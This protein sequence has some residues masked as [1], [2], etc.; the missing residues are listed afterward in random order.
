MSEY[1]SFSSS[2]SSLGRVTRAGI[3]NAPGKIDVGPSSGSSG[4]GSVGF[5]TG[6]SRRGL[7]VLSGFS[8]FGP[9]DSVSVAC[10]GISI[11]GRGIVSGFATRGAGAGLLF[12]FFGA[13]FDRTFPRTLPVR[14][15]VGGGSGFAST[16]SLRKYEFHNKP[17]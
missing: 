8:F 7:N 15:S 3:G 5:E 13:G 10:S 6:S 17:L 14:G 11:L 16:A 9:S 4:G 2:G 1:R 12:T